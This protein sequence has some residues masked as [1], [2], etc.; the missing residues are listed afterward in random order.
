MIALGLGVSAFLAW[1]VTA[2]RPAA[3]LAAATAGSHPY[4]VQISDEKRG[5]RPA[6]GLL[7]FARLSMWSRRSSSYHALLVVKHGVDWR[8][9]NWSHRRLGWV[10]VPTDL[11]LDAAPTPRCAPR[12]DFV[13]RLGWWPDRVRAGQP[14]GDFARIQSKTYLFPLAY[15]ARASE[16]DPATIHFNALWPKFEPPDREGGEA[17]RRYHMASVE[18]RSREWMESLP[19]R[20]AAY[21]LRMPLPKTPVLDAAGFTTYVV[22]D[23]QG[24]LETILLCAKP[25]S[26]NPA[27]CQHRFYADGAIWSF[28]QPSSQLPEWREL[29]HE[30]RR[31]LSAFEA[32]GARCEAGSC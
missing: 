5:Y 20:G 32:A 15:E 2:A 29:Q 22:R 23:R 30:F 10:M 7:D 9:Y 14:V 12:A 4:C 13:A 28:R 3:N 11:P 21:D 8:L 19:G 17:D 25:T 18:F 1:S 16:G 31:R 26:S 6:F 27:S 24:R